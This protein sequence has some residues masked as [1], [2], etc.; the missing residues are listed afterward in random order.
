MGLSGPR[1]IRWLL[2]HIC[3]ALAIKINTVP[4]CVT[5]IKGP[6]TCTYN[7]PDYL[8]HLWRSVSHPPVCLTSS[9]NTTVCTTF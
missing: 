1:N 5:I 3:P 2:I 4:A 7:V 8:C 9:K 6:S